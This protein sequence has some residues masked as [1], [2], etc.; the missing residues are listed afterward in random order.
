MINSIV[1]KVGTNPQSRPP[2]SKASGMVKTSRVKLRNELKSFAIHHGANMARESKL[3][4][5]QRV[6]FFLID[7]FF[8]LRK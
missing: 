6:E 8:C 7:R 2:T 3:G 5:E 1:S 4:R